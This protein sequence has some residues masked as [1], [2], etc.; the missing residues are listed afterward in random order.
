MYGKLVEYKLT[1][2]HIPEVGIELND[3]ER[4]LIIKSQDLNARLMAIFEFLI[5]INFLRIY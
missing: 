4:K 5:P 3:K 1:V 2:D